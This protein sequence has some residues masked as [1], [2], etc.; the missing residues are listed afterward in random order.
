MRYRKR[1]KV[2]DVEGYR[3]GDASDERW[4]ASEGNVSLSSLRCNADKGYERTSDEFSK[5][6]P[7][8]YSASCSTARKGSEIERAKSAIEDAIM[9]RSGWREDVRTAIV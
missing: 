7:V 2:G 9:S 8:A 6:Q 3:M 4:D 1:R 5:R